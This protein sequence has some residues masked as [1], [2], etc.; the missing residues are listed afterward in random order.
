MSIIRFRSIRADWTQR[1]WYFTRS[2]AGHWTLT[3][4][5]GND[6]VHK[7]T[8]IDNLHKAKLELATYLESRND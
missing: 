4:Y 8:H 7:V 2:R 6:R 3:V 1:R 5:E